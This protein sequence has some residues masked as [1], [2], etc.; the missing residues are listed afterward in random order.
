MLERF[1]EHTTGS[2]GRW[3]DLIFALTGAPQA[4]QL[5]LSKHGATLTQKAEVR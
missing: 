1:L 5:L 3:G 2:L 4:G